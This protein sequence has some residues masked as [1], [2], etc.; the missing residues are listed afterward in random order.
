[1]LIAPRTGRFRTIFFLGA[2]LKT[3]ISALEFNS[4]FCIKLFL[5][6]VGR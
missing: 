4:S 1:M 3:K 2:P 6:L 5:G